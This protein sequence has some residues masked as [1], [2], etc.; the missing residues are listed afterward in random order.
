MAIPN[1][2]L[3]KLVQEIEAQAIA[4][5]QQIGLV[6]SQITAKQRDMRLSELTSNELGQVPPNTNVYEGV[7]DVKKRL[8]DE[9]KGLK[10][11]LA[12][13]EKRLHYL[14]TTFKNSRAQMEQIFRSGGRS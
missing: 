12:N 2:A 14:E 1:E 6:K 13:L 10:T 8:S 7:G 9:Q 11:D 3:Q 4:S 5:Q